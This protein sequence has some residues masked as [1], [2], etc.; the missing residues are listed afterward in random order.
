MDLI[1]LSIEDLN[2]LLRFYDPKE[3]CDVYVYILKTIIKKERLIERKNL[4]KRR[5]KLYLE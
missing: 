2:Y 5:N 1:K 3:D 4:I